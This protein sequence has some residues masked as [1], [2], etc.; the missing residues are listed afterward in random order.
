MES[1]SPA[2]SSAC[3]GMSS[4]AP[5]AFQAGVLPPS[6][7]LAHPGLL[8]MVSGS[9]HTGPSLALQR[10]AKP[11]FFSLAA[12]RA[13]L[14]VS[15][16][17]LDCTNLGSAPLARSLVQADS[18]LAALSSAYLGALPS[19][20]SFSQAGPASLVGGFAFSGLLS[21]LPDLALAGASFPSKS[22]SCSETAPL[23]PNPASPESSPLPRG[24]AWHG[25]SVFPFGS[26]HADASL[27]VCCSSWT[28][29]SLLMQSL[30]CSDVPVLAMGS[31][32][33]ESLT[34]VLDS[35]AADLSSLLHS[36]LRLEVFVSLLSLS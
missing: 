26:V 21:L 8:P 11:G 36:L 18:S 20:H 15:V 22:S 28:G 16:V 35:A 3:L 13:S 9:C 17:A 27:S 31:T 32:R 34:F 2:I 6:R 14:D 10:H 4:S 30:T 5:G 24:C 1:L 29:L 12:S 33:L 19:I 23:V 7:S 25:L